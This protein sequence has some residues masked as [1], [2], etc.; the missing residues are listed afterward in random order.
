MA[1]LWTTESRKKL[2]KMADILA[3]AIAVSLP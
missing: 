3:V 2:A 1:E